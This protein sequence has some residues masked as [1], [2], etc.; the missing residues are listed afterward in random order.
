MNPQE[1]AAAWRADQQRFA[2]LGAVL[3]DVSMY[4]PPELKGKY[5]MAVEAPLSLRTTAN[6]GA[7]T[8]L[9]TMIDPAVFKILYAPNKAAIIFGA[10]KK[11]SWLDETAMFP[12]VEHVGEVSSY[13]DYS[14]SGHTGVNTNWPQRQSYL[15]QT[16][17]E[18]GERELERAGLA[19][20]NWVSEIDAAAALALNK[21]DR[22]SV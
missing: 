5:Q 15:F 13:G 14:E 3:P 9:T 16:I 10:D 1:A 21:L 20:I 12:T 19:R 2:E 22:K 7:P 17:K 8:M 18:Y 6:C 4:V 11:G